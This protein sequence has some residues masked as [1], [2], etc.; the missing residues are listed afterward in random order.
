MKW[1]DDYE[2]RARFAPAVLVGLPW[3]L[4]VFFM[5]RVVYHASF[6][7]VAGIVALVA[8]TY[9]FSFWCRDRGKAIEAKLWASW[10]GPPSVRFA[11]WSDCTFGSG[12]KRQIH[13]A[14]KRLCG[15]ELLS[16]EDE[17][18]SPGTADALITDAFAH[19]KAVV[20]RDEPEGLSAKHNA[21]Y[22]FARNLMGSRGLWL[23]SSIL[24]A[25]TS[26]GMW[27]FAKREDELLL[28]LALDLLCGAGSILFGWKLL[29]EFAKEAADR[30]GESTWSAFRVSAERSAGK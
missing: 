15:I 21:E 30:Y 1:P 29:P 4:T 5:L 28:A 19:V 8:A 24:T 13:E 17:R 10:G 23:V 7:F 9:L 20:R 3:A 14:V 16:E 18:M 2:L 11:R 27:Y 25:A 26:A 12:Q 22:G 6:D